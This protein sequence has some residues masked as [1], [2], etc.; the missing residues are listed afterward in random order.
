MEIH[1]RGL[2][3]LGAAAAVAFAS[4]SCREQNGAPAPSGAPSPTTTRPPVATPSPSQHP[5]GQQFPGRPAPG[6]V[7]YGAS[8]PHGQSVP[9]WEDHLGS[10]LSLHRSYFDPDENETAQ[11]VRQCRDDLDHARLP[12][13][14]VKPAATWAEIAAGGQDTWLDGMLSPLGKLDAPVMFTLH[15]EPEND[16]GGSGMQPADYV[17]MQRLLMD[18]AATLAPQLLVAPV[19][20]HWT[21]DPLH[22]GTDPAA[23]LVPEA[24]V[25][26]LDIYNPWSPSN[27]KEWRSFGSKLDEVRHW[28]GETPLVIG[29][30]GC[31][32]DHA[33]PGLTAE[34]LRDA[35]DYALGHNVVSMSYFNSSVDSEEGTW[36]LSGETERTFAELLSS[37]WVA[38]L[39]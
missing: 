5:P 37:D 10:R 14:S 1:R 34:W 25:L 31:R 17:A 22:T 24:P 12:H 15:H 27:G 23:W 35:A 28:F 21:F 4:S 8:V 9:A 33:N 38:R 19:L 30:Y 6:T 2:L 13:V 7:Y 20:Q 36:A 18:H 32:E 11:L 3:G 26:G 39:S 29:E 16:S